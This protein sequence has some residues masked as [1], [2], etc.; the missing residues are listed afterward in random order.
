M[1]MKT[2]RV[3][4]SVGYTPI[5]AVRRR[6]YVPIHG[7]FLS[8]TSSQEVLWRHVHSPVQAP[9][10]GT[11]P[12]RAAFERLARGTIS[13]RARRAR[14]CAYRERGG[15]HAP[16]S[17]PHRLPD[18]SSSRTTTQ[19][20]ANHAASDPSTS[21]STET[22]HD[23]FHMSQHALCT[24]Q[25]LEAGAL[26]PFPQGHLELIVALAQDRVSR[27]ASPARRLIPCTSSGRM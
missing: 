16:P 15:P 7:F 21:I 9:P 1:P 23:G 22:R 8:A 26:P 25:R 12:R 10:I 4:K 5:S 3:A 18:A 6:L 19:R 14:L 17:A 11:R 24:H 2:V 13:P 27:T 20:Q